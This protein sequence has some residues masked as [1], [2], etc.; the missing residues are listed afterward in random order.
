MNKFSLGMITRAK[1][2]LVRSLFKL[3]KWCVKTGGNFEK[4]TKKHG[5]K[6]NYLKIFLIE[7]VS[8]VL[9]KNI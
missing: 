4:P 6:V 5:S 3:W 9:D 2:V 8:T 7:H 1:W